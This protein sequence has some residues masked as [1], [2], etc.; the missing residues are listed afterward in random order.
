[1]TDI[2]PG[3]YTAMELSSALDPLQNPVYDL[4]YNE[5]RKKTA[6]E[7]KASRETGSN[8]A[9]SRTALEQAIEA[10]SMSG[11]RSALAGP[12]ET[13]TGI[14]ISREPP[15]RTDFNVE[16]DH[17]TVTG[18]LLVQSG[19]CLQL[20]WTMFVWELSPLPIAMD[21][22]RERQRLVS[23]TGPAS[24]DPKAG[25]HADATPLF[26]VLRTAN[27][28][29]DTNLDRALFSRPTSPGMRSAGQRSNSPRIR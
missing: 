7:E 26:Q 9:T 24:S 19:R 11:I 20:D 5:L 27:S 28:P 6:A 14:Y 21:L 13:L 18:R 17:K 29:P 10:R 4:W 12:I 23:G 22:W 8:Q 25:F 15:V 2:E 3:W 1:M 16:R